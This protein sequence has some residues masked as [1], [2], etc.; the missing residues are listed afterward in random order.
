MRTSSKYEERN[1][2]VARFDFEVGPKQ[3]LPI[4]D[5]PWM[6]DRVYWSM[7]AGVWIVSMVLIAAAL[8]VPVGDYSGVM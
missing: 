7:L 6:S 4:V 5:E 1:H 2:S 3:H 8:F